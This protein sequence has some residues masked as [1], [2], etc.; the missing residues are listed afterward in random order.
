[1]D[2]KNESDFSCDVARLICQ[3]E[4][5]DQVWRSRHPV[6]KAGRV[7]AHSAEGAELVGE[8]IKILQEVGDSGSGKT[9]PYETI[10]ELNKEYKED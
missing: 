10:E 9:F 3:I 2:W 5:Y 7:S 4:I 1:M 8:V 6:T